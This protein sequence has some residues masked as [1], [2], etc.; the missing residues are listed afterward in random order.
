MI[1]VIQYHQQ[2]FRFLHE[3]LHDRSNEV[4]LSKP[5]S[6]RSKYLTEHLPAGEE[7]T[8][9]SAWKV[10]RE[11]LDVLEAEMAAI[12]RNR[13]VFFWF[14]LYRR[15]GVFLH[16]LH[17]DKTDPR[18]LALVRQ[19][20]ELAILKY[21]RATD[22]KEI[23]LSNRVNPDLIL[24]G[25]M[26][27]GVKWFATKHPSKTYRRFAKLVQSRP[28]WVIRDFTEDDFLGIY[29]VEGLAYQY[30]RVTALLRSLG[31]GA[32]IIIHDYGGW[33]YVPNDELTWLLESI[34]ART[35]K[36]GLDNSLLGTWIDEG[37]TEDGKD[38]KHAFDLLICPVYNVYR[39][40]LGQH[41]G[42]LG[43][44]LPKHFSSNFTRIL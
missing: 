39:V 25:F 28:Q 21:G 24:G 32:R 14:H 43:L 9:E 8:P 2:A 6:V 41:L 16:P 3:R 1:H 31:K 18:T 12:L 19:I 37:V 35:E 10:A 7:V 34:D 33:D 15:I 42:A 29:Y 36:G 38:N 27:S 23:V 44:S 20:A 22:A 17:E 26:R 13:S 40:K 5:A 11:L 30:W 4:I